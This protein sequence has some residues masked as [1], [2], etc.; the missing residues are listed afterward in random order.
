MKL[1]V[2]AGLIVLSAVANA[3]TCKLEMYGPQGEHI[4]SIRT[5]ND[6]DCAKAARACYNWKNWYYAPS[7]SQCYRVEDNGNAIIDYVRNPD[8][9]VYY[10]YPGSPYTRV[11][12]T[13]PT[14]TTTT[15]TTVCEY[16]YYGREYCRSTNPIRGQTRNPER[17]PT[18]PTP[19]PTPTTPS[20]GS[21]AI[22][23]IE[24]GETVIFNGS[25][26]MV[27]SIEAP[28]FYNLKPMTGR[29]RER[30][31][32]K[33][34]ARQYVAITRGCHAGICANES[35]IVISSATYS[36]VA[37]IEYD[38]QFVTK[39]VTRPEI[40]SFD[41]NSST[42][43]ATKGCSPEGNVK[44]CVGNVVMKGRIYYTVAGIQPNGTVV[45]ENNDGPK[46]LTVNVSPGSLLIVQ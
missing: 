30:D 13:P 11:P 22:R 28:N 46:R 9:D 37:G 6:P 26:H 20:P 8:Y 14:T 32:V 39:T 17:E 2:F 10:G 7:N 41:V 40:M 3:Q 15:N 34:V 19:N 43:A 45:I 12:R 36:A 29:D 4:T 23:A 1:F 31:I 5:A 25:A 18:R 21:E 16:D 42:L 27:V 35:V 44:V 24:A 38:G 33:D